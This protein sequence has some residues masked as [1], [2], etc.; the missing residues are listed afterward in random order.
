M[1]L[2]LLIPYSMPNETIL[3]TVAFEGLR[4]SVCACSVFR[5]YINISVRGYMCMRE[6]LC[7]CVTSDL[8]LTLISFHLIKNVYLI[9]QPSYKLLLSDICIQ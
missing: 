5:L 9:T 1:S 3:H 7:M 2:L 4:V 6:L 8:A